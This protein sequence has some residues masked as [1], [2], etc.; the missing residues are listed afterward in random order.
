MAGQ[1]LGSRSP[2]KR[3]GSS[4]RVSRL[5]PG[6]NLLKYGPFLNG[7]PRNVLR[8]ISLREIPVEGLSVGLAGSHQRL[9]AAIA[10]NAVRNA[11]HPVN[12]AGLEGWSGQC[13]MAGT[14]S[15]L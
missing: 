2:P 7:L 8:P 9:N 3:R 13:L 10:V 11:G 4:S 14:L 15:T 6:R 1:Y 5:S 12:A